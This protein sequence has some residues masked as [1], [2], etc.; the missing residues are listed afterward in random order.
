[1][2][3]LLIGIQRDDPSLC[4]ELLE[5]AFN[6]Q[7]LGL[8]F[9]VLQT[10]VAISAAG[11]DRLKRAVSLG[12]ASIN[13]Y[14]FLGWG[15]SSDSLT[16]Q[17]LG[18]LILAIANQAEG[19]PVA[20][21][22]LSMRLYSDGDQKVSLPP[23]LI[24]AGRQLL[25]NASF[26]DRNS[27]SDFYL[28]TIANA[29]LIGS[30]AE[31]AARSL[32]ERIR[33]GLSDY[34]FTAYRHDQLLQALFKLQPRIALDVF[35][36]KQNGEESK[37]SVDDFDAPSDRRK[38]P[39]DEVPQA[40]ILDWCNE[41]PTERYERLSQVISFY[42]NGDGSLTWTPLAREMLRRAPNPLAVL[43]NFVARFS[44][45]SWMGSRAAIVEARLPLLEQLEKAADEETEVYIRK[46]RAEL[47]EDI[48]RTRKWETER[49]SDR[50]ERFEN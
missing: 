25:A 14:Q 30:R 48:A 39:L 27:M 44:P 36:D 8:W 20:I 26:D 10:S 33:K 9:P 38:N 2:A 15:R 29:C 22:V 31:S 3:G 47:A 45:R 32:C 4:E 35:F 7:T 49:D 24:D 50:D 6:H 16:G 12:K 34:T 46:V 11:A 21:D 19:F 42:S 41:R 18:E 13:S 28:L 1:M 5:Y 17:D 37:L 43:R 23:E 40:L